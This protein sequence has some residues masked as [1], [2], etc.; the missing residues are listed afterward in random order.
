MKV[1]PRANRSLDQ[2][3]QVAVEQWLTVLPPEAGDEVLSREEVERLLDR[4]YRFVFHHAREALA[5]MEAEVYRI[6]AAMIP[7]V[8]Q[9]ATLRYVR[10]GLSRA[11]AE[12]IRIS[13]PC[14]EGAVRVLSH[15]TDA[16]WHAHTDILQQTIQRQQ[17]ERLQQ[18]LTVAKRIQQSLLPRKIPQVAHFDVAGRVLSAADIGGDYWSCKN[19][20][21]YGIV[22]LKLADITGHGIA[23]AT[24]V[25]GVKFISGGYFRGSQSAA[26]VMEQTNHVLVKETPT[27]ILVT[28]FYAWLRPEEREIAI[29]NAGHSPVLHYH[30]GQ[31]DWI[32]PTGVALGMLE[33]RYTETHLKLAPGDI[34]FTCSDG[35]TEP[36]PDLALG[37]EWV[38]EQL[39]AGA[40]L[41]AAGLAEQVLSE[42]LSVYRYPRDDM[43]VLVLKCLE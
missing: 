28:M 9:D 35:V 36:G 15:V 8:G 32:A 17:R 34:I 6:A 30:G 25:A 13:H 43:S 39:I 4:T 21:E 20:E 19:W 37:E 3:R 42:A 29:V 2:C 5:E 18:E 31:V 40:S 41:S 1:V 11:L 26:Q 33:T 14:A 12:C 7:K 24:L 22:T 10:D 16:I 27:E 38:K 23:A